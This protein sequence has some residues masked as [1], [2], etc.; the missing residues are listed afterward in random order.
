MYLW[1]ICES[2]VLIICKLVI[3]GQIN[4]NLVLLALGSRAFTP[5]PRYNPKI[6][7]LGYGYLQCGSAYT[8]GVCCVND[9]VP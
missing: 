2:P 3:P 7:G 1:N 5:F 6:G 4:N 9:L 8:Q